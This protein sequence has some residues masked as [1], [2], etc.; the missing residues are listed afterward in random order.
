M[1]KTRLTDLKR[2]AIIQAAIDEFRENGFDATSMDAVAAR[3][4]VSKRTLYNHFAGKDLLFAEIL[5]QL[6]QS[7]QPSEERGY[8]RDQPLRPQLKALLAAKMTM[9]ADPN[10]LSLARVLLAETIHSPQRAR[11]M[12]AR[13]GEKEQGLGQ[14]LAAAKADGRLKEVEPEF[15]AQQLMGMIKAFAFWPQLTLGQGVL[16]PAEADKVVDGALDMFLACYES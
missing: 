6:W 3:A 12:V 5:D 13:L 16:S 11:D 15:A 10:F 4:G 1:T 9:L 14:W 7:C 2:H 8:R